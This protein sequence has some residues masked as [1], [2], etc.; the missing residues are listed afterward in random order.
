MPAC[1][2][3]TARG[4]HCEHV[5]HAGKE[6]SELLG[7]LLTSWLLVMPPAQSGKK[8]PKRVSTRW[9]RG[10]DRLLGSES[11]TGI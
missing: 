7:C 8:A 2:V 11:D 9:E 3:M 6:R 1:C 5:K 10:A 4:R